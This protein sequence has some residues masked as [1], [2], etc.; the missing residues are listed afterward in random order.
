ML[1]SSARSSK[2]STTSLTRQVHFSN[3]ATVAKKAV[4]TTAARKIT[5]VIQQTDGVQSH[6][7]YRRSKTPPFYNNEL[8]QYKVLTDV[9][10]LVGLGQRCLQSGTFVR[11]VRRLIWGNPCDLH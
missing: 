6:N 1:S 4:L 11:E 3:P 2:V 5:E 7:G 8:L 9:M 10:G